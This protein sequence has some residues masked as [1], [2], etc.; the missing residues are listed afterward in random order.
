VCYGHHHARVRP[1]ARPD[2]WMIPVPVLTPYLSACGWVWSRRCTRGS[3]GSWSRLRNPTVVEDPSPWKL[4]RFTSRSEEAISRALPQRRPG[5]CRDAMVGMRCRRV[6]L[7]RTGAV[8]GF[9]LPDCGLATASLHVPAETAS[10]PFNA[11]AVRP[12]GTHG[13]G[14]AASG[15]SGPLIWRRGLR[16][17]SGRGRSRVGEALDFLARG[18]V[19]ARSSTSTPGRNEA[20]RVVHG[21]NSR[22]RPERMAQQSGRQPSSILWACSA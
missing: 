6:A 22:S 14:V 7:S 17:P 15:N 5:V 1:A 8:Y 3:G 10:P 19:R 18:G 13:T 4:F 11:L 12:A 9:G 21:W 2:R 16:G 20:P